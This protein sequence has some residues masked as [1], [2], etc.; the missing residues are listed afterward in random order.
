MGL[1]KYGKGDWRSIS[2]NCVLTKT[3]TQVASHAQKYFH[4]LNNP[5]KKERRRPSIHD[6]KTVDAS[7]STLAKPLNIQQPH[8][9][10]AMGLDSSTFFPSSA[11]KNSCGTLGSYVPMGAGGFGG[12][13]ISPSSPSVA[14]FEDLPMGNLRVGGFGNFTSV[15]FRDGPA[16]SLYD[17]PALQRR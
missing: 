8:T 9:P 11:S 16:Y 13:S 1:S 6:I 15:N 3:P 7:N 12:Q 2:R 5:A 10:P 17:L 14:G 4:R